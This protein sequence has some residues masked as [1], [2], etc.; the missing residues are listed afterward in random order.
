[1]KITLLL[2]NILLCKSNIILLQSCKSFFFLS[3]NEKINKYKVLSIV[4]IMEFIHFTIYA[5]GFSCWYFFSFFFHWKSRLFGTR[6]CLSITFV[7]NR[8]KIE[9]KT[10]TRRIFP[11]SNKI[12]IE[13]FFF[14]TFSSLIYSIRKVFFFFQKMYVCFHQRVKDR[15]FKRKIIGKKEFTFDIKCWP[16]LFSEIRFNFDWFAM[17]WNQTKNIFFFISFAKFR[18]F[19]QEIIYLWNIARTICFT[20]PKLY[21]SSISKSILI[22]DIYL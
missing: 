7:Y 20:S 1:M 11:C 13:I 8:T 4:V 16:P 6:S 12:K 9:K 15:L 3:K 22:M 5:N 18:F 10:T 17:F 21:E 19:F 2:Y 14:Y